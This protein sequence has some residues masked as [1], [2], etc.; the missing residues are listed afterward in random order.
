MFKELPMPRPHT[1]MRALRD[2]LRLVLRDNL[3]R[4]MTARSLQIPRTSVNDLVARAQQADL[5]WQMVDQLDDTALEARLFPRAAP[6]SSRPQPDY[7]LVKKELKRKG[8]TLSLLWVEYRE[9]H[10]GGYEYSQFCELY[11]TWRGHLDVVM[12]FDHKAGEK[13]FVDYPGMRIP[14]YDAQTLAVS[15]EAELFVAVLGASSYTFA[16]ATRSQQLVEWIAAHVAAFSFFGGVTE[17]LVPDNLRSGVTRAHRYE[18]DLNA[19][20][21][22]LATHYGVAIIPARP[23][24]PR[25]KA[26]VEVAVQIAERWII[27]R[28]RHHRF[29]SLEQCNEAIEKLLVAINDKPFRKVAGSRTSLYLEIDQPAL[30]PLPAEPYEFATWQRAKVSIDYHVQVDRN[31][32]SVPYRLAGAVLDVRASASVVE[33]FEKNRRVASHQ[34]SYARGFYVTDPAHMPESH[35]RHLEWTPSRI[36]AWAAKSGPDTAA[37][38]EA[39]MKGRP[40]PEQGFRSALGVLRLEKKYGAQ[41]LNAA[42]AR[43]LAV[44]SLTYKSVA[45]ILQHGLDSQPTRCEPPRAHVEHD[46]LRGPN[47]YQ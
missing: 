9:L 17:I 28:L 16:I 15:F 35:R 38:I 37:F 41:R 30:A 46:N 47:Y 45:S 26:K 32:Y 34:R 6:V 3:S 36:L 8:V 1:T 12:R 43:A 23:Y 10:P 39:L 33:I 7:E 5:T 22:D 13:T 31:F 25:D 40:H 42:C 19:T 14:I 29:T 27:A 11:R 18:P 2:V 21:Q 4:R 20:Y 24:K 44:H